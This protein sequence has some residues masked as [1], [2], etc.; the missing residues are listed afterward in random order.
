[1]QLVPEDLEAICIEITKPKTKPV[2]ITTVYRP[3][4]SVSD[5]MN[6]L[7]KF[8]NLLDSE[9][10]RESLLVTYIVIS[11]RIIS[12][13]LLVNYAKSYLFQLHQVI[14]EPTRVTKNHESLIDI[15][16]IKRFFTKSRIFWSK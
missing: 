4:N 10:K 7:E 9:N 6:N 14:T 1:M 5:Y 16:A 8:L 3:P 13:Q 12:L 15:L 2:L 11:L